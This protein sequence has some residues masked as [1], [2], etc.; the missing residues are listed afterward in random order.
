MV[1]TDAKNPFLRML[2]YIP[3]AFVNIRAVYVVFVC[4]RKCRWWFRFQQRA[5]VILSC[6]S[7]PDSLSRQMRQWQR[8]SVVAGIGSFLA[9][10]AF[11]VADWLRWFDQDPRHWDMSYTNALEPLP[12]WYPVWLYIVIW[13]VFCAFSYFLSQQLYISLVLYGCISKALLSDIKTNLRAES[14]EFN[15]DKMSSP[16]KCVAGTADADY[17]SLYE[18]IK[19]SKMR[20]MDILTFSHDLNHTY[21]NALFVIY[22]MDLITVCGFVAAV[23]ANEE[24]FLSAYLA[25]AISVVVFGAYLCCLIPMV[26]AYEETVKVNFAL[27]KLMEQLQ[28]VFGAFAYQKEGLESYVAHFITLIR[29]QPVVF[30]GAE[31]FHVTRSFLAGTITF[32][33]SSAIVLREVMQRTEDNHQV[34]ATCNPVNTTAALL[35]S[36][37]NSSWLTDFCTNSNHTAI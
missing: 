36:A 5:S 33:I 13:N 12:I 30:S 8:R 25:N 4:W 22:G 1:T 20:Y 10:L 2:A 28:S 16:L 37:A 17:T 27:H 3:Y 26:G 31:L 34:L 6:H 24:R 32:V 21:G 15:S 19:K 11:E 18:R 14:K 29:D 35:A 7:R 9:V 23:V